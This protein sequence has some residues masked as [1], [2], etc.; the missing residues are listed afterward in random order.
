MLRGLSFRNYK[1]FT[2]RVEVPL[3]RL[4]ILIGRNGSGKTAVSRTIPLW[5][6]LSNRRGVTGNNFPTEIGS[7]LLASSP[8]GLIHRNAAHESMSLGLVDDSGFAIEFDLRS[9]QTLG[10]ASSVISSVRRGDTDL[11]SVSAAEDIDVYPETTPGISDK[12]R[13]WDLAGADARVH[14]AKAFER[15]VH[16][17][18]VRRPPERLWEVRAS[19]GRTIDDAGA[20]APYALAERES[21]AKKVA[22]LYFELFGAVL[23]VER[24]TFSFRLLLD[25]VNI[26]ETGHGLQQVL[27]ILSAIASIGNNEHPILAVMEEPELHLHPAAHIGVGRALVDSLRTN[28]RA[29]II[30]E[31][32][33]ENLILAVRRAIAEKVLAADDVNIVWFDNDEESVRIRSVG[34]APTG[35]VT[36]WPH[37][38]FSEGMGEIRAIMRAR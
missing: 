28:K 24:D 33:S 37:G 29:Q 22:D 14:L 9:W 21:H 13:L 7:N 19:G 32:H 35:D 23:T 15:F 11:S 26:N 4:T 8:S 38:V 2:D 25:G 1:L 16:I 30:V 27:P 36:N 31:T 18:A 20:W 12:T 3:N 34:V 6:E 17:T 10:R 5:R